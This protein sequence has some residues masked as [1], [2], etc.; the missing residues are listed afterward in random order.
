MSDL[1]Q[2]QTIVVTAINAAGP[3]PVAPTRT[4]ITADMDDAAKAKVQA[5]F[6]SKS[7]AHD[8]ALS[9]YDQRVK[10]L[11]RQIKVA[12]SDRSPIM[13]QLG[14]L[15]KAL[16]SEN[17]GGKVFVG[18]VISVKKEQSSTRG[19]VTLYTGTTQVKDGIP[20]GCEQV[21]TERTDSA[22][23]RAI[24]RG[25]QELVGH[26]V[27]VYVELEAIRGGNTKVRVLRHIES[28]G[29]DPNYD[30][31]TGMVRAAAQAA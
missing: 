2:N 16:D 18:T 7:E 28:N 25:A 15:D 8:A 14:A 6:Q 26:R 22:D 17:D 9:D 12:L 3:A 23:G 31:Q 10:A 5:D 24:A 1:N 13:V 21:R 4:K 29:V 20:A 19:I 30:A 11:A 27:T